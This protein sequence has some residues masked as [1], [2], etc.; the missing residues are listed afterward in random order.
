MAASVE[1]DHVR[2]GPVGDLGLKAR[3]RLSHREA[4]RERSGAVGPTHELRARSDHHAIPLRNR[5]KRVRKRPVQRPPEL[6]GVRVDDPVGSEL[7]G[8]EPGHV[9]QPVRATLPEV[10]VRLIDHVGEPCVD[11]AAEDLGRFV[12]GAVVGDHEVVHP[13]R[14]VEAEV[15]LEDVAFVSNLE[16]HH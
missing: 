15:G 8:G 16:R 9:R 3:A 12:G 10:G 13:E 7:R 11:V 2:L 6:V 1:D 5:G 4:F 14:V